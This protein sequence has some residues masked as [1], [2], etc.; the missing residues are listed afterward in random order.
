M[1]SIAPHRHERK[2][3]P[4]PALE[5]VRSALSDY[6]HRKKG[7]LE[8]VTFVGVIASLFL[9]VNLKAGDP[10]SAS[11][12]VVQ[13]LLLAVFCIAIAA[14]LADFRRHFF[15]SFDR[16]LWSYVTSLIFT[17]I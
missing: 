12:H 16:T 3:P 6:Y 2:P 15:R 17:T 4:P 1:E 10:A 8:A 14:L 11:L 5:E 9:Q 13:A 7:R